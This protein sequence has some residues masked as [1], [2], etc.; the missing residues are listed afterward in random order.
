MKKK[1]HYIVIA[2][3]SFVTVFTFVFFSKTEPLV[4]DLKSISFFN[5][6]V[7][8]VLNF[9]DVMFDRGVR[10]IIEN[11]KRDPFEY[12]KKD[13]DKISGYDFTIVNLEGPIVTMDRSLCQDKAYN[14]QFSPDTADR[15]KSIGINMVNIAN[16][17]A[18]DCYQKGIDSTKKYLDEFGILYIGDVDVEK[19]FVVKKINEK[20]IAFV[21]IDRTVSAN[22]IIK[23]YELI[24]KLK[25]ENDFVVVNIHWGTEYSLIETDS[26]TVVGHGLVDSGADVVFGHHPHVIEPVR[27]Y[28]NKAIF[29]S[30]G[31]F[32]FDQTGEN[33]NKGIGVGVILGDGGFIFNIYPYLIK[34]F[35]PDFLNGDEKKIFCDQYIYKIK[36]NDCSFTL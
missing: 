11:K 13:L 29:Y 3:L 20:K 28:K 12:I 4:N 16:N 17:H 19:S 33:E 24:K 30:L 34:K 1:L 18:Y 6:K 35:A 5:K 14:F 36:H 26:Q 2:I 7:V 31:N 10:N 15:L 32:V 9:G 22:S 21:G 25:S 8:S 27:I 23:Y